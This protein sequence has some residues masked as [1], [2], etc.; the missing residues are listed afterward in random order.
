MDAEGEQSDKGTAGV[1]H[2]HRLRLRILIFRGLL[3]PGLGLAEAAA[4][5]ATSRRGRRPADPRSF[6]FGI[7]R[8]HDAFKNDLILQWSSGKIEGYVNRRLRSL[9][10]KYTATPAS[11]CSAVASF[12]PPDHELR[13]YV[14]GPALPAGF[15]GTD[16]RAAGCEGICQGIVAS[17]AE[18]EPV[19]LRRWCSFR[20]RC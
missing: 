15:E 19:T 13:G 14:R 5:S 8:D 9:N 12:S 20:R 3:P 17:C 18:S 10:V 7:T 11:A 2:I 6:L 1:H 16:H 4:V